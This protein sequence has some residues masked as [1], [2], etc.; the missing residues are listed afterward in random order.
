MRHTNLADFALRA[1]LYLRVAPEQRA[2]VSEIA[3]GHRVSQN[4]MEKVIQRL[5]R[6]GIVETSRG[7]GGG[8]QLVRDPNTITVGEVIRAMENDL[9][10]VECLGPARYCR[11]AGV[12][13]GRALFAR[14]LEAY[15]AVLDS[16]TIEDIAANDLGLQGALG[17]TR[18]AA[19]R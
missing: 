12:C 6:A 7:R 2:S 16:E 18:H 3:D 4:H 5:S 13:G 17:L 11:I 8:V 19:G 1:L 14:A 15:L 9:A 10:V